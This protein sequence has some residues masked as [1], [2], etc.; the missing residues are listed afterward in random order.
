MLDAALWWIGISPHFGACVDCGLT[1]QTKLRTARIKASENRASR[2]RVGKGCIYL[3]SRD[4][5]IRV[6][7]EAFFANR[8]F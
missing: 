2:L 6:E 5:N 3:R 4:N 8:T 7:L 1:L